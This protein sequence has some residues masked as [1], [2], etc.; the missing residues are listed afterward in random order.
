MESYVKIIKTVQ[1]RST[2]H[3]YKMLKKVGALPA[4]NAVG[5]N[6]VNAVMEAAAKNKSIPSF[7]RRTVFCRK[8]QMV[9]RQKF[10]GS[11]FRQHVHLLAEKYG[12]CMATY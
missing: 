9:L 8:L 6:S 4:V 7:Q 10:L 3:F 1:V 2:K 5:T 12:I 11:V